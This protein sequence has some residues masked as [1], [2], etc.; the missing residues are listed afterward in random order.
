MSKKYLA[1][2]GDPIKQSISPDIHNYW[3][4]LYNLDAT[5][6]AYRAGK[7][8]LASTIEKLLSEGYVGFNITVP[9]KEKAMELCDV[10]DSPAKAAGAVNTI[11]LNDKNQL[12]GTNTDISG[13]MAEINAIF[14]ES[15]LAQKS[16]LILGAGGAAKAVIY[17][18]YNAGLKEIFIANRSY[19]R[20]IALS[21]KYS[22]KT[23]EW[24]NIED[25][26]SMVDLLVNT[27]CLGMV[28]KQELILK[29]DLLPANAIVYDIVYNPLETKLLKAARE[30]GYHTIG[31]LPMLINQAKASFYKWFGIIPE[32]TEE[33]KRLVEEKL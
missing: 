32:T 22:C 29:L 7:D 8:Q 4:S 9:N 16:C 21:Q 11:F 26:L 14:N 5:Y 12:C 17:G 20:A 28:G 15:E 31:G 24:N 33:L 18:L 3:I 25:S 10:L 13:F 6:K 1:V 2:I 27:T 23:I 19:D 30:G